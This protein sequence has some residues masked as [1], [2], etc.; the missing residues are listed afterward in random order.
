MPLTK[1]YFKQPKQRVLDGAGVQRSMEETGLW[2]A[3][4]AIQRGFMDNPVT[5][6]AYDYLTRPGGVFGA[7]DRSRTIAKED[8]NAN[9]E[10][11]VPKLQWYEGLTENS[12][13]HG[14]DRQVQKS[15]MDAANFGHMGKNL[16][17]DA[18]SGMADPTTYLPVVGPI[19]RAGKVAS[20]AI[21]VARRARSAKG[22][23]KGTKINTRSIGN[24]AAEAAANTALFAGAA[25]PLR[26]RLGDDYT[27]NDFLV[28]TT[29]GGILGGTAAG[30][31]KGLGRAAGS[32]TRGKPM[33]RSTPKD[34]NKVNFA[35][36]SNSDLSSREFA[37]VMMKKSENQNYMA[38]GEQMQLDAYNNYKA[39]GEY[40]RSEGGMNAAA[41]ELAE[42]YDDVN[43]T[44]MAEKTEPLD[45][46]VKADDA[47]ARLYPE[48]MDVKEE[49]LAAIEGLTEA[50]ARAMD[51]VPEKREI[52][53]RQLDEALADARASL[54]AADDVLAPRKQDILAEIKLSNDAFAKTGEHTAGAH[55]LPEPTAYTRSEYLDM[56]RIPDAPSKTKDLTPDMR[57]TLAKAGAKPGAGPE[58]VAALADMDLEAGKL[59]DFDEMAIDRLKEEGA[60]DKTELAELD[61]ADKALA[62][63]AYDKQMANHLVFCE[64]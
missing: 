43:A 15:R 14:F 61:A 8:W 46:D 27:I 47:L 12:A 19:G 30:I 54:K 23:F 13:K 49:A 28:E 51:Y 41:D 35:D 20:R 42:I 56:V 11:F 32:V 53:L 60:L 37:R 4:T 31:F 58:E 24:V 55:I 36:G 59:S 50:R 63:A 29:V 16:F 48:E 9:H 1:Q 3:D 40:Q 21:Q 22:I 5:G 38:R 39:T 33:I 57:E 45:P 17:A 62:K 18:L 7:D 6:V 25:Y 10:Y 2:N 26:Q 64:I 52:A 44:R 34:P